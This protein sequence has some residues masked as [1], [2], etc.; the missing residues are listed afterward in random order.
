MTAIQKLRERELNH[1]RADP[2]YY[3]E[4]YVHIEDKD[5]DELIQPF[6]VWDGQKQALKAFADERR[7]CVLKARQLGFTWLALAEA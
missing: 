4:S 3:V 6:R 2:V 1:C 5:A 7:V